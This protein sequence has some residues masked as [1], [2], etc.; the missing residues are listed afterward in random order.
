MARGDLYTSDYRH[1][2]SGHETFPLRYGWLKKAFDSVIGAS[3]TPD[4]RPL[5][6]SEDA[7]SHFGVGKNMVMSMR[8]WAEASGIIEDETQ[9]NR[10]IPTPLGLKIFGPDGLDPYMESPTTLWLIHWNLCGR[11]DRTTWYWA[12]NYFPAVTFDR[13]HLVKGLMS[14]ATERGWG[15]V[16]P[17]TVKRDVECFVRTYA[18]RPTVGKTSHEDAQESPLLELGLIRAVGKK[19]GFR[20]VRGAKSSLSAG[21]FSYALIDF[22]I[23]F[24]PSSTLSFETI[25]HEP[26]SPG[27]VF[28]MDE[29]D[30]RTGYPRLKKQQ[31]DPF[32]G[33]KQPDLSSLSG[34]GT[35]IKR[36]CSTSSSP[37]ITRAP[38]RRW[39]R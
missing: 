32:S 1:Q 30:L 35:L 38:R 9:S 23:R 36:C 27:R 10:I 12:F 19:D 37:T 24:S 17:A 4:G 14:L 28:L 25:A 29:N 16:S 15:R 8:Y 20:F 5:L 13:E 31:M 2:F 7:I 39:R 11:S 18:S 3:D 21:V 22:W 33:L 26:G 34:R 6:L